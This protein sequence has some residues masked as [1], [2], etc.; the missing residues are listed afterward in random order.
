M[1]WSAGEQHRSD[2]SLFIKTLETNAFD[3]VEATIA[4]HLASIKAARG[5]VVHTPSVSTLNILHIG[6]SVALVMAFI[7]VI[8]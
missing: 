3:I 5:I 8:F 2:L 7:I 1:L 6:P 4:T